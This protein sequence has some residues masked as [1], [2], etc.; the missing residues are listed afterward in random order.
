MLPRAAKRRIVLLGWLLFSAQGISYGDTGLPRT[1][2]ELAKRICVGKRP[3]TQSRP[4]RFLS[5]A[6]KLHQGEVASHYSAA[7][8]CLD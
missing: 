3:R 8:W 1:G 5:D 2:C 6:R 7:F 4:T